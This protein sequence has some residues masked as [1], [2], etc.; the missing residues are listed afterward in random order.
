MNYYEELAP[1]Y[2][3]FVK[4]VVDLLPNISREMLRQNKIQKMIRTNLVKKFLEM[5]NEIAENKKN[6]KKVYITFSKNLKLGIHENN[7]SMLKLDDLLRD[8]STKSGE[9][10]AGWKDYVTRMNGGRNISFPILVKARRQL[11]TLQS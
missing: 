7:L 2:L 5:F 11:K 6:Y 8:Y 9:G 10:L 1:N 3:D 4:G